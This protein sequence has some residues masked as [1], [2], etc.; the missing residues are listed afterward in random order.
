MDKIL[1]DKI[2]EKLLEEKSN[3]SSKVYVIGDVDTQGDEVDE[4]VGTMINS[5]NQ[6]LSERDINRLRLIDNALRR[7]DLGTFGVCGE[8]E[9]NISEKRLELNPIVTL[10]V[11]CA[12]VREKEQRK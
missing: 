5:I 10:C 6:S 9:E 7:I 4:I 8:C 2:R 11:S 12:E 3:I 1:M